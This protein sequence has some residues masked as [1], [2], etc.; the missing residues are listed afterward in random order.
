MP[1]PLLVSVDY[2]AE[3]RRLG[4]AG[5]ASSRELRAIGPL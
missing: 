1:T 5:L 4:R 3:R 2:S